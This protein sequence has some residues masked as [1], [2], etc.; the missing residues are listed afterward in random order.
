VFL[1]FFDEFLKKFVEKREISENNLQFSEIRKDL[2][3]FLDC[4]SENR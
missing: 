2:F 1:V 4:L 3:I